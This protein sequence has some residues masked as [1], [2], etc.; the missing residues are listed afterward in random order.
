MRAAWLACALLLAPGPA[1][2][3]RVWYVNKGVPYHIGDGRFSR[4]ED[5]LFMRTTN[6]V[7][8]R[9]EQRFR[10]DRPDRV[11]VRIEKI[12][13]V[14]DCPYCRI[15]I[16]IDGKPMGRLFAENNRQPFVTPAPLAVDVEPGRVHVLA[17]ESL[18]EEAV[19]DFVIQ[20][21]VVE[22]A[23]AQV[24]LLPGPRILPQVAAQPTPMP[25]RSQ[26]ACVPVG[27]AQAWAPGRA[28]AG[29]LRE[30]IPGP[31]LRPGQAVALDLRLPQV[32]ALDAVSQALELRAGGQGW[33][34]NL[35]PGADR[36]A[37]ANAITPQ[38]HSPRRWDA[39]AWR[40]GEWNRFELRRCRDGGVELWLNG[41]SV[42]SVQPGLDAP[43]PLE[44]GLLGVQAEWRSPALAP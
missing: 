43:V 13:G 10:V 29:R 25:V 16:S 36:V 40:P 37:H 15:I 26:P 21:V 8:P 32:G 41:V 9:W 11:H 6:V 31:S 5:A 28:V 23:E 3:A 34:L 20:D 44:L 19:D 14:D 17:I 39:G 30:R 2:A 35:V 27:P 38:G 42:G 12:W 33:A 18:G 24:E 1:G 7:G 4:S 22:T